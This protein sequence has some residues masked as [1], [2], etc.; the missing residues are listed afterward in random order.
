MVVD[1]A[2]FRGDRKA[3]A[4]KEWDFRGNSVLAGP[5][6]LGRLRLRLASAVPIGI[7]GGES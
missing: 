7:R 3:V 1:S 5:R 4:R 2:G 6:D